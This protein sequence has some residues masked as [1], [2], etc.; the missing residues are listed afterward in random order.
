VDFT[1]AARAWSPNIGMMFHGRHAGLLSAAGFK[2]TSTPFASSTV[3]VPQMGDSITEGSIAAVLKAPGDTVAVDEV[4]AQ[5]ETDK[6][7]I[8]VRAPT[9][10]VIG[11]ILVS[12]GRVGTPRCQMGYLDHSGCQHLNRVLIAKQRGENRNPKRRGHRQR[13]TGSGDARGSRRR[14]G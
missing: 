9:A 1:A 11:E 6:V 8:D 2:T 4:I 10:G 5:I 12:E 3:E 13:G 14:P 7:T